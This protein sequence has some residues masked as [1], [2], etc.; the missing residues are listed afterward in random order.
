MT[1]NMTFVLALLVLVCALHLALGEQCGSQA[2][3]A[4]CPGNLCCSQYGWCGT[5]EE[6]CGAGCQ[7]QC[8][9]SA[10]IASLI[11]ETMFN[12]LFPRRNEIYTYANFVKAAKSYPQIGTEGSTQ[13]RLREVAAF[14]AHVQQETAG[15]YYTREIDQSNS[16]CDRDNK[17]YPCA[18]GQKYFGRGPLQLSWNYNYGAARDSGIGADILANPDIVAQNGVISFRASFWFWTRT[19]YSIPSIHDVMVG[20]WTPTQDDVNAN[21]KPGFGQTINIINGGQE[22]GRQTDGAQNRINGILLQSKTLRTMFYAYL[23]H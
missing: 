18:A 23:V 2:H 11:D 14:A 19:D 12:K 5:T 3:F 17:Q 4:L 22:C 16:Y 9:Q 8:D 6:Y 7:S 15:L 13:Q 10:G 1:S 21:R 20:K